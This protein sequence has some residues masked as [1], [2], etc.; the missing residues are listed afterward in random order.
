MPPPPT[1]THG[2]FAAAT[3]ASLRAWAWLGVGCVQGPHLAVP[4]TLVIGQELSKCCVRDMGLQT[5]P[6]PPSRPPGLDTPLA[7]GRP[8]RCRTHSGPHGGCGE[9][10]WP[11]SGPPRAPRGIWFKPL[12]R[13]VKTALSPR[14]YVSPG[15]GGRA[16]SCPRGQGT[17]WGGADGVRA[18]WG[19]PGPSLCGGGTQLSGPGPVGRVPGTR[20]GIEP[21]RVGFPEH[22]HGQNVN[23]I[24]N[25]GSKHRER[26]LPNYSR[27]LCPS[28]WPPSVTSRSHTGHRLLPRG[29]GCGVTRPTHFWVLALAIYHLRN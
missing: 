4:G 24:E 2:S 18:G 7:L 1:N 20:G 19:L 15:A 26:P 23:H 21:P 22:E 8:H 12:V 10:C 3:P 28:Q 5:R 17:L 14:T 11:S 9:P 29:W 25:K 6:V 16:R 27:G 13:N